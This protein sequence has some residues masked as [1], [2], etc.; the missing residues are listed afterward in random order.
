MLPREQPLVMTVMRGI[1]VR[2]VL[3]R[4][5]PLVNR[6]PIMN[7]LVRPIVSYVLQARLL[8]RDRLSVALAL[9][10]LFLVRGA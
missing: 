6:I 9:A 2:R 8:P 10:W 1:L 7:I 4:R 3:I 5:A